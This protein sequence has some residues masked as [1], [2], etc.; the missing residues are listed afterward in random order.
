M[1]ITAMDQSVVTSGTKQMLK[2]FAETI[3]E[4]TLEYITAT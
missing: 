1:P 4:D 3:F 2:C